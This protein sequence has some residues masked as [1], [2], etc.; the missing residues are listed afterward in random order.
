M[1]PPPLSPL[2]VEL[3]QQ[4]A[5]EADIYYYLHKKLDD[6]YDVIAKL[7][8]QVLTEQTDRQRE[9]RCPIYHLL[10]SPTIPATLPHIDGMF[11]FPV[12]QS[13]PPLPPP[14]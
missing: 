11:A 2:K 4:K 12:P 13:L 14:R 6:N 9:V 7:E 5:D 1:P 10:S 8:K 3:E